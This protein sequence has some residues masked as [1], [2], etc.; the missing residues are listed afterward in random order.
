VLRDQLTALLLPVIRELG[1]E[2]WELEYGTRQ[3]GALLRIYIDRPWQGAAAANEAASPDLESESGISVDD[4][5]R[6]SHAVSQVLDKEDPVAGE[7][8][9]EVSSPG[10]DR[11]LRTLAHFERFVGSQARVEMRAP[12]GGRKRFQGR[13]LQVA[14]GNFLLDAGV[15]GGEVTLPVNGVH[16]AR[17]VPEL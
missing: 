13:L 7:Y 2:L 16:K 4:C 11:V 8:T 10:L 6:V 3:G 14:D 5:A 17:L 12:V 9:L 1:L 15:D